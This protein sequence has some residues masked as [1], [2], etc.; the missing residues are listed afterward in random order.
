[1]QERYGD[2]IKD[3]C[4]TKLEKIIHTLEELRKSAEKVEIEDERHIELN[5]ELVRQVDEAGA[6][7]KEKYILINQG[8]VGGAVR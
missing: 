6:L 4:Q 2:C 5:M 1:M 8:G 7:I 3:G